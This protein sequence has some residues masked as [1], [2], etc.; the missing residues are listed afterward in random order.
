MVWL[1]VQ[2]GQLVCKTISSRHQ[3]Y[4]GRTHCHETH[5]NSYPEGYCMET[6]MQL[7]LSYH[8]HNTLPFF[9]S[10]QVTIQK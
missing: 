8:S 4:F 10:T 6:Y 1:S 7:D 2:R 5:N 3:D 9:T